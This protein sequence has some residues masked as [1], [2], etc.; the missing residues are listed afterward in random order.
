MNIRQH[1]GVIFSAVGLILLVMGTIT[2]AWTSHQVGI[3]PSCH[4]NT[5]MESTGTAGLWEECSNMSGSPHWISVD[6]CTVSEFR[7]TPNVDCPVPNIKGGIIYAVTLEECAEICCNNLNCLSFQY[8]C[9][10]TCFLKKERCS[11]GKMKESPCG[12]MYERPHSHST[13]YHIARFCIMLSTMLLLPGAFL[14]VSA[15]CKGDLDSAVDGYTIFT[16]LIIFGGIA[17]GIGAAFYTIDHELYGMDVP[18]SVSF[19]LTWA[20]TFF[21]VPGGFLIWHSTE[22]DDEMEAPITNKE[23]LESP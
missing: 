5:T 21:S 13:A 9:R 14:A 12:N 22:D 17:G 15:A 16:T 23:E 10:Q 11:R 7:Y 20:Q 1:I 19:Y 3:W 4:E 8:N 18:F 2:P 6:L